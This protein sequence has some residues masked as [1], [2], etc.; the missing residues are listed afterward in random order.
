MYVLR[1]VAF[2]DLIETRSRVEPKSREI[3]ADPRSKTRI[4]LAPAQ[5]AAAPGARPL[6]IRWVLAEGREPRPSSEEG[7]KAARTVGAIAVA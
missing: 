3:R 1:N 7:A 4:R 2:S 5:G 6:P